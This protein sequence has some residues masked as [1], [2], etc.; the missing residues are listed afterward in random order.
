MDDHKC[1]TLEL[2]SEEHADLIRFMSLDEILSMTISIMLRYLT[3][4]KPVMG[5]LSSST[6]S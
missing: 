6:T 4:V 3:A 2:F 5:V 1:V